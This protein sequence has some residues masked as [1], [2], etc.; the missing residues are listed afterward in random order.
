MLDKTSFD[1]GIPAFLKLPQ[2]ARARAWAKSPPRPMPKFADA[3]RGDNLNDHDR[4]VI[5]SMRAAEE[6][7]S[8]RKTEEGLAELGAWKASQKAVADAEKVAQA[9]VRAKALEAQRVFEASQAPVPEVEQIDSKKESKTS[10]KKRTPVAKKT[11]SK[12]KATRK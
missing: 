8:R 7:R 2:A 12:L 5:A 3:L 6:N 11:R 1:D 10:R 4:A 9:E